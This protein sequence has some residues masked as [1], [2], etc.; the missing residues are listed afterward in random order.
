MQKIR[1]IFILWIFPVN[2]VKQF[3]SCF[4]SYLFVIK[5]TKTN[6]LL[7]IFEPYYCLHFTKQYIPEMLIFYADKV[8][9]M[10]CSGHSRV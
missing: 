8:L 4:D 3:V 7:S 6:I 2:F 10:G 5:T 9:V 1:C